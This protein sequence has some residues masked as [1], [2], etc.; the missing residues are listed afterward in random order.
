M[1]HESQQERLIA[2]RA[3]CPGDDSRWRRTRIRVLRGQMIRHAYVVDADGVAA[4]IIDAALEPPP[5][6]NEE[7]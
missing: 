6:E 4:R 2:E 3:A 1:T 7:H 5:S